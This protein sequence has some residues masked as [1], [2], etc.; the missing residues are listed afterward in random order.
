MTGVLEL[1]VLLQAKVTAHNSMVI[2]LITRR[3]NISILP[4]EIILDRRNF[5]LFLGKWFTGDSIIAFNPA[6]EVDKL[7]PLRTEGTK[8][9]FFPLDRRATGW[10]FH[11]S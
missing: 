2:T 4:L 9:I 11:E 7:T 6:T 3:E 10:T 1:S 5:T 8:G